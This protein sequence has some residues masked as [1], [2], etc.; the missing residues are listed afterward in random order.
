MNAIPSQ[1][2]NTKGIYYIN[3][4]IFEFIVHGVWLKKKKAHV[5]QW[6]IVQKETHPSQLVL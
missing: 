1:M 6:N 4:L 5:I 2:H 3:F